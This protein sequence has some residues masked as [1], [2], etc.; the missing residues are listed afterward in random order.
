MTHQQLLLAAACIALPAASALADVAPD[1]LPDLYDNTATDTLRNFYMDEVLV[2]A[3]PKETSTFHDQPISATVLDATALRLSGAT[4]LRGLSAA[5]PGFFMPEYGSRLTSAAYV[6]G[7]GTRLGMP[8]LGLYVDNIPVADKTAYAFSFIDVDRVDI[9]RGPQATLY[10]RNAMSG[11]VRVFTADPFTHYGV[12]LSLGA[13]GRSTGRR[14]KAVGYLHPSDRV[15]L[16]VGAFYEGQNGFF[17]NSTTGKKADSSDAGGGRL[18]LAA[19][20]NDDLRLDLTATY[21]YSDENATPYYLTKAGGATASED[22]VGKITQNRQSAYRREMLTTGLGVEWKRPSIIL[23]SISSFQYLRD[24]LFMDQDFVAADFFSLEQ[25]QH[26]STFT[27]ELSLKSSPGGRWQWTSGAYFMHQ[28]LSTDCPVTFYSDGTAY[29]N[30]QF[31]AVLPQQ[32]AMSLAFTTETLPFT[33]DLST[34]TTGAALFHQSTL[35]LGA[36]LSLTA[37]L[38]LDYDHQHLNLSAASAEAMTYNLKM[39]SF[40]VDADLVADPTMQGYLTDDTWQLLPKVAL[41]Y[42]HRSGRGNVYFAVSKGYRAGGYNI[43]SYSDL[44]QTALTRSMMNGVKDYSIATINAMP[45]PDAVK[46]NA[47]A[48][49]TAV[50]DKQI[51]AAP[52]VQTLAYAPEQ[53]WNYELGGHLKFFGTAL[54]VDYAFFCMQTKD[55]Q[56]ARFAESGLGRI[57]VNAGKTR[58]LGAELTVRARL[59][60]DRLNLTTAYGFTDA[61]FTDY[62]LGTN[63]AGEAVDYT[64]NRVPFAPNHTLGVT[65][66]FRQPVCEN[67]LLR[68]VG[69]TAGVTG[70]GRFYWDEANSFSQPFYATL[71]T[72]VTAELAG[73]VSVELW[74]R[75]LTATG[76]DTF[77]FESLSNRFAQRG[78]PRCFGVDVNIHF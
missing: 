7:I 29:L 32:P 14:A 2:V 52:D 78:M 71:A 61:R 76:Y 38:R 62:D 70:A 1:G 44:A 16:S 46:Q 11:L 42:N 19:K 45:L 67:G 27:E 49:M 55:Q 68:A 59:F 37:G 57:M 39:P 15:A 17:R 36:G 56:I 9:L 47:I 30:R 50:L 13:T 8:A 74:G 4:D 24:R 73:N 69:V 66:T 25:R 64:D 31:A 58:S 23:S 77:A 65:A 40:R 6:R 33:A 54:S 48:G 21:E 3:S 72:T 18:R 20:P 34:P 43:Q 60:D 51:P 53:T 41:Q 10:G 35:D 22:L 12:D 75:N 28:N 63:K 26:I 5:A